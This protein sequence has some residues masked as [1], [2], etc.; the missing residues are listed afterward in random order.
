MNDAMIERA[1]S[2]GSSG[3]PVTI[4]E[5]EG[6][7]ESE[8]NLRDFLRTMRRR[9]RIAI[10]TFLTVLAV[11]TVVTLATKPL[12]RSSGRIMVE[13]KA[14]AFAINNTDD[15]MSDVFLPPAGHEVDTQVEILRSKLLLAKVYT[16]TKLKKGSVFVDVRQVAQT[17]VLEISATADSREAA[18]KFAAALPEVY[19]KT[20][21]DDRLREVTTAWSFARR[22]LREQ[23]AELIKTEKVLEIFKNKS[24]VVNP[25]DQ[26]KAA[27]AAVAEARS[28]ARIAESDAAARRESYQALASARNSLPETITSGVTTTNTEQIK[29]LEQQIAAAET[30]RKNV[31]FLYN[32]GD[33][34]VKKVDLQ[35]SSLK[36]RLADLPKTSTT[37][38]R[39]PNAAIVDYD[40][41]VAN[42]RAE[43]RAAEANRATA[44]A[45][46]TQLESGL[47][48]FNPIERNVGQLQRDID[49]GRET[50][51]ML[52]KSVE[53]LGLRQKAAEAASNPVTIIAS[54]GR[55]SQIAPQVARNI[56]LSLLVALILASGAALL[57]ESLDDHVSDEE[58]A[59]QMLGTPVLG[60]SPFQGKGEQPLLGLPNSDAN[61]LERFRGLRSNVQF[62]LINRPNHM[63]L[64]TSTVPGEGKTTTSSNLAIAMALDK[65]NVILVDADLRRP[66]VHE[67]FGL[68]Q[69][70]GLTHVLVGQAKLDDVLKET[71]VPGLRVLTAGVQPPNS[72]ELL[73]SPLMD[74]IMSDLRERAE[75]VIFD[76]PPCLAAADTQIL[77]AKV[78][79]VLYVMELGKIHKSA[80]QRS[81]ELLNQARAH[82]V[83]IVFNKVNEGKGQDY[84]GYGY[85]YGYG[86]G[87][88]S[89]D[90]ETK[91][92]LG[93]AL[94]KIDNLHA[95]NGSSNA[96]GENGSNGSER[97]HANGADKT[98]AGSNQE[99]KKA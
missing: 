15:P 75:V 11:G 83:G 79:G 82:I 2:D 50:V 53:E 22:R 93:M 63:L 67:V 25:E 51:M 52:S 90:D 62:T 13:G 89:G 31:R 21:K 35:I 43:M 77:S 34:E 71:H 23:K 70:M 5:Q 42:A 68:S 20:L 97:A 38:T 29:A 58:E 65:R 92:G 33:D 84:Y 87:D 30:E 56:V 49:T 28:A 41:S 40:A 12:Y 69:H 46:A 86:N 55:G 72:A 80:V 88:G 10:Q 37:T 66:R 19:I 78:D 91:N 8:F 45:R 99:N 48:V 57:Q 98:H 26:R 3:R 85:G 17:D 14:T 64:V 44:T 73:N 60:H 4:I 95:S 24:G 74:D 39:L 27:V 32:E 36:Q 1:S 96:N 76:S 54:A 6:A 47:A 59:R 81:F 7:P 18:E 9:K 94:Q 61:L 16:Y